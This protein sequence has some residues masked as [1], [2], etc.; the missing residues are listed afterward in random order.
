MKNRVIISQMLDE[1]LNFVVKSHPQ[2]IS[3]TEFIVLSLL[4]S[5]R[6]DEQC[7]NMLSMYEVQLFPSKQPRRFHQLL[8]L[9]EQISRITQTLL[10]H[11]HFYVPFLLI[12]P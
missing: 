1:W 8:D 10:V 11:Q 9:S 4:L 6:L 2:Q 5:S 7:L 12:F 3:N